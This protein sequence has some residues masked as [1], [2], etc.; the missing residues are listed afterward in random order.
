MREG[1]SRLCSS[2]ARSRSPL[3]L[4]SSVS[5]VEAEL[6]ERWGSARCSREPFKAASPKRARALA[7]GRSVCLALSLV[8][9]RSFSG[10]QAHSSSKPFSL[11]VLPDPLP[12]A[13]PRRC[14]LTKLLCTVYWNGETGVLGY[15]RGWATAWEQRC[16][17]CGVQSRRQRA[18]FLH[19]WEGR[20]GAAV[21]PPAER[22]SR[23]TWELSLPKAMLPS[24]ADT[25]KPLLGRSR[26][27][28]AGTTAEM[29]RFL[30]HNFCFHLLQALQMKR[31]AD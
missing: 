7:R 6:G 5:L 14:P 27:P 11:P 25:G 8:C 3:G 15:L 1:K 9:G 22:F 13:H 2:S 29:S 17:A 26:C 4:V 16:A 28:I 19:E 23:L 24:A 20:E 21:H 12:R 31:S 10:T 30:I 18:V